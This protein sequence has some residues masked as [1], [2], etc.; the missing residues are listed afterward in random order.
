MTLPAADRPLVGHY[1]GTE[2]D[3]KWWKRYRRGGFFARG[4][5]EYWFSESAFCFL[6]YLTRKP[7]DIPFAAVREVRI[8]RFHAGR[9]QPGSGGIVKVL[10]QREGL[11]LSSGFVVSRE[12]EMSVAVAA[13]IRQRS[14][15][16]RRPE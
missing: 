12:R 10:W 6:R 11:M 4:N 14:A 2:I 5:G 3:A 1:L 8:G 7:L 13:G 9:W 16:S 15:C